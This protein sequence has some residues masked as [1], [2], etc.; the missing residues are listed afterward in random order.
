M[1]CPHCNNDVKSM[2]YIC[3][4][5][6]KNLYEE[7]VEEVVLTEQEYIQKT[8]LKFGLDKGEEDENILKKELSKED[9]I[10]LRLKTMDM[11]SE[12]TEF[13]RKQEKHLYI[14]RNILAVFAVLTVIAMVFSIFVST[15]TVSKG[16]RYSYSYEQSIRL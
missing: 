13:M 10:F 12:N 8:L 3:P 7:P 16:S 5:C 14:I 11:L 6:G 2:T 1:L 15:K 9:E 4:V